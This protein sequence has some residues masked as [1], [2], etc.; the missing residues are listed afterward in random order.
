MER[1]LLAFDGK[2]LILQKK[3]KKSNSFNRPSSIF[4]DLEGSDI[5]SYYHPHDLPYL[6]QVYEAVVS[7]QVS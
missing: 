1:V 4:Q 5:F 7:E 3:I 6:K 2:A